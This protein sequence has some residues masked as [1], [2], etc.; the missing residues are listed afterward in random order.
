MAYQLADNVLAALIKQESGG[1]R[2][3]V[4]PKGARG[5][6]QIMPATARAPG[7]G[8]TPLRDNSDSEQ[9]RFTRDYMGALLKEN[10]GDLAKSLAAYN[11]G[12]GNVNKYGGIPPFKETRNYVKN[13][14]KMANPIGT[15]EAS[16]T[17]TQKPLSYSE[18][19][20]QKASK[21]LSY[22]EW[23]AQKAGQS[24]Q[25]APAIEQPQEKTLEG[26]GK[27]FT[28]DLKDIGQGV[29]D[30]GRTLN[31]VN[32][33]MDYIRD[34]AKT[35]DAD[36]DA[37]KAFPGAVAGSAKSAGNSIIHPID[38]AYDAPISTVMNIAG[39]A[40]LGKNAAKGLANRLTSSVDEITAI[41]KANA[42]NAPKRAV[43]DMAK[44]EG[45][46]IPTS[47]VNPGF[48]RNALEGVAGKAAM[49]QQVVINN[50]KVLSAMARK[51]LGLAD[52]VPITDESIAGLRAIHYKPYEEI[53][54]LSPKTAKD[55]VKWRQA[56]SDATAWNKSAAAAGGRPDFVAKADAAKREAARLQATFETKAQAAGKPELVNELKNARVKLAE[57]HTLEDAY[58][59]ATGEINPNV[60]GKRLQNGKPLSGEFKKI[61]EF[62]KAFPKFAKSAEGAQVPGVSKVN[63]PVAIGLGAM[64]GDVGGFAT[65]MGAMLIPDAVRKYMLSPK[66]QSKYAI[67]AKQS[68]REANKLLKLA[69]S[70]NA[71]PN[72]L[73]A[74]LLA[75]SS[76]K[77]KD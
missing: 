74:A 28:R 72:K 58:N 54:S 43:L 37:L 36:I 33:A 62:N 60:F 21:P 26:L 69:A 66:F 63:A 22:S 76:K 19:K 6:T 10:N 29:I 34:P 31:P 25:P 44:K 41:N 51:G 3:A 59:P 38:S 61:A 8:V 39:I 2:N 1:N 35:F 45:L 42:L 18:W 53:A 11:A 40:G 13:I 23:K 57:I 55:L 4:S 5:L 9:I 47:E 65:G 56:N 48:V 68:P 71:T 16:E 14:L 70:G 30:M 50:Q 46:A 17:T 67:I 75:A 12:Q 52:D 24:A 49:G 7:Y 77:D 20:A 15:V 73:N 32:K 64:V 27:N